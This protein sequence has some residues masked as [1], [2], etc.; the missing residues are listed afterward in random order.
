M[1]DALALDSAVLVFGALIPVLTA[2]SKVLLVVT[3]TIC[4]KPLAVAGA[5]FAEVFARLNVNVGTRPKS[6]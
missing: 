3:P 2:I 6:I 5:R 1:I 4:R